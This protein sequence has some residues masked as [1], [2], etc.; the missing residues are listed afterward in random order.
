M[1]DCALPPQYLPPKIIAILSG[2]AGVQ[3]SADV[4]QSYWQLINDEIWRDPH[5]AS[6]KLLWL[7]VSYGHQHWSPY[8][9]NAARPKL[10][11]RDHDLPFIS[12]SN[13]P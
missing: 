10:G 13:P 12:W 11:A 9:C 5:G 1:L 6:L 4:I 3:A 2:A 7:P 8:H